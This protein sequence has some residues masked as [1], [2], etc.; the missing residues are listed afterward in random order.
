MLNIHLCASIFNDVSDLRAD[1]LQETCEEIEREER[2]N[3]PSYVFFM[4]F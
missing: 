4:H 2:K 3:I 1:S